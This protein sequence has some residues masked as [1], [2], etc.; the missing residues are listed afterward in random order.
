MRRLLIG[1]LATVGWLLAASGAYAQNPQVP[2]APCGTNTNQAASTA[3]ATTCG[4]TAAITG[5]T[6][7]GATIGLTTPAAAAFTQLALLPTVL[8]TTGNISCSGVVTIWQ[9]GTPAAASCALPSSPTNGEQHTVEDWLATSA[10][11]LT[12]TASASILT[13]NGSA[14]SY[15]LTNPGEAVTFRYSGTLTKWVVE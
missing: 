9:P 1:F 13:G 15:I 12:V 2:T 14:T 4:A 8:T 7:N 11:A 3:F 5:G 10:Y 6:I